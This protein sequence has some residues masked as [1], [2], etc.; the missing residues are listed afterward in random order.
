MTDTSQAMDSTDPSPGKSW[1]PQVPG[2]MLARVLGGTLFV[3]IFSLWLVNV[4]KSGGQKLLGQDWILFQRVGQQFLEGQTREIYRLDP[5]FPF[6]YPPFVIY[7]CVPVALVPG[8]WGYPFCLLVESL[9]LAATFRA[10]SRFL[11]ASRGEYLTLVLVTLG[12]APW[13]GVLITGHFSAPNL[14]FMVAGFLAWREGKTLTAGTLISGLVYK[15]NL[16][17]AYG[18]VA[19]L[20]REWRMLAGMFLCFGVL[21]ASSLPLGIDVWKDYLALTKQLPDQI[22]AHPNMYVRQQNLFAFWRTLMPGASWNVI[23]TLWGL[24]VVSVAGAAAWCWRGPIRPERLPRLLGVTV[25][26]IVACNPY[27]FFY[28]AL[29]LLIPG[30]VWFIER[31]GYQQTRRRTIGGLVV[32]IYFWQ[33]LSMLFAKQVP[34]IVGAAV[35]VWVFVE[36]WD[37]ASRDSTALVGTT[38]EEKA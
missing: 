6:L 20:K 13:L 17:V 14:F 19:L 12:S 15:P 31:R 23:N 10:L 24:S 34:S 11:P 16:G 2:E 27:L 33:H 22:R 29:L 28:D 37:L 3:L 4:A 38:L 9:M 18:F 30:A 1:A 7:F 32:L 5:Q 35:A 25:L 26:A 21:M 36:A 8:L